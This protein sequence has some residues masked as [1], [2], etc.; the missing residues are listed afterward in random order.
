MELGR[1]RAIQQLPCSGYPSVWL[2]LL[3]SDRSAIADLSPPQSGAEVLQLQAIT[4]EQRKGV[5]SECLALLCSLLGTGLPFSGTAFL[6]ARQRPLPLAFTQC[7]QP[8]M[9]RARNTTKDTHT[10]NPTKNKKTNPRKNQIG[11]DAD[12]KGTQCAVDSGQIH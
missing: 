7:F 8:R 9:H 3:S 1:H 10:K 5:V 4:V 2:C 6:P 11:A 12:V